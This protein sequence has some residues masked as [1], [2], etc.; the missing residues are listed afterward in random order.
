MIERVETFRP[1]STYQCV[2]CGARVRA[3]G[4][5][6]IGHPCQ[7]AE[8]QVADWR[9]CWFKQVKVTAGAPFPCPRSKEIR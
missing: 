7:M 6:E 4:D 8:H 5:E 3:R 2:E 9:V 1:E